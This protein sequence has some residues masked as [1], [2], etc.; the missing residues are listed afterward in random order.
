V[1]ANVAVLEPAA[2]VTDAGTVSVVLLTESASDKPPLGAAAER[3]TVQ[4]ELAPE[5]M[6]DG[7]HCTPEIVVPGVVTVTAALAELPL[8]DA[9][10]V[11]AWLPVTVPAVTVKLAA[12]EPAATVTEPGTVNEALLAESATVPPPVGAACDNVTTHVELLPELTVVGAHWRFVTVTAAGVTVSAAVVDVPF[13]DAVTV[14]AWLEVT[15]PAVAVK[16][17]LVPLAG[18]VTDVGMVKALPFFE[19]LT[20]VP[21][22][23]DAIESVTLQVVACP[24]V[25][26]AGAHWSAETPGSTV[27]APPVAE[28]PK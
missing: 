16:L 12:V 22:L 6:L 9:V 19:R 13:N 25:T 23:G 11:T 21:P 8:I 2:T 18:T 1:A 4:L 5:T 28:T 3:V 10:I 27:I 24:E 15:V 14:A 20:T 26:V 17:A 7:E